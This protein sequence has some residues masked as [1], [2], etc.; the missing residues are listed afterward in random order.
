MRRQCT[1]LISQAR[2]NIL[3]RTNE[4][5]IT[6]RVQGHGSAQKQFVIDVKTVA[7][8]DGNGVWDEKWNPATS[9]HDNHGLLTAE[10]TKYCKHEAQY[11]QMGHSFVAFVCSCFGALGPSAIRYLWVF[12]LAMLELRQHEALWHAQ[13]LD[14]LDDSERAQFRVRRSRSARV[15]AAMAKAT[16]MRL[17]GTPALPTVPPFHA[18]TLR[19][20]FRGP[21]ILAIFVHDLLLPMH[22]H[23]LPPSHPTSSFPSFC[24]PLRC[25]CIPH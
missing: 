18:S 12:K 6:G 8:V 20:T 25:S 11:A 24:F 14:P 9:H 1:H 19:T 13:G 23:P 3:V 21:P 2:A 5:A 10:Q 16:V 7:M 17:T 15:A 22:A 4:L